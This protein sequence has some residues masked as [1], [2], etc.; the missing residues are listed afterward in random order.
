MMILRLVLMLCVFPL[1]VAAQEQE[2]SRYD[3]TLPIEISADQLDVVQQNRLARFSGN[4]L[5]EQGPVKLRSQSMTVHYRQGDERK[6][7]AAAVSKIEVDGKV[8]LATPQESAQGDKGVYDVDRKMIYLVG[9][10]VLTRGQNV[11]KGSN[12]QYN[13]NTGRSVITGGV[14]A[15][16]GDGAKKPEGRVRG[17]F[18]PREVKQEKP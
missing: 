6:N 12:L 14:S 5:A 15:G 13:L 8:F 3:T 17:V 4:V 16:G 1:V 9:N 7:E 10:V 2:F 18:V 11:L